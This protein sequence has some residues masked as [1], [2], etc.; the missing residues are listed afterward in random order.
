[1]YFF[2]IIG[3]FG[4]L[5]GNGQ[6]FGKIMSYTLLVVLLN[7]RVQLIISYQYINLSFQNGL[8]LVLLLTFERHWQ[9]SFCG[10]KPSDLR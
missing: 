6:Y 4:L 9:Q 5:I 2:I 7:R 1:M 10:S 8:Q 3:G